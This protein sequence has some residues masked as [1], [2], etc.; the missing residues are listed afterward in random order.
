VT[1]LLSRPLLKRDEPAWGSRVPWLA[2]VLAAAW[3][4]VAG[5]ALAVLPAVVVWID[6]GASSAV[7]D[8]LRVGGQLWLLAHGVG[9]EVGEAEIRIAPLGLSVLFLL[10]IYR[11][12]RWAAHSA[13]V[14]TL[15]GVIPVA[16][17]AVAVYALGAGQVAALAAT[18]EISTVPLDAV[19]RA[20]LAATVAA[21]AGVVHEADLTRALVGRLPAWS[22]PAVAGAAVAVAG[23]FAVGTV[24]FAASAAAHAG[25]ISA[26][27]EALD[28]DPV[29]SVL[30]ALAGAAFV[31][32]LALWA[33][34]FSLGPGFAVGAGTSVAPGGVELGIVPALPA[35]GA[36][37][38]SVPGPVVW[39]VLAGPVLVGVLTGVA[40]HRGSPAGFRTAVRNAAVA[41]ALAAGAVAL[42][43][44]LAGGSVGAGR[45]A[46]VGP[47]HW[48]VALT[49]VV[50]V[51]APAVGT[52]AILRRRLA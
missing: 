31:P 11:A 6:D 13:G 3:A 39:L 38:A 32:N 37:P 15:R 12:A 35:L 10:L 26:V 51:G 9:L 27:A 25:R 23:L 17:P 1:D 30:L 42:L 28:P 24:L 19:I 48:Q 14:S 43:A 8:P 46:V 29:G 47:V 49:T 21:V 52:T 36:L 34:A 44:Q 5:L 4:L 20:G 16:I 45:L 22:R 50:A 40:V 33:V 7:G 41:T 18:Q 2:G